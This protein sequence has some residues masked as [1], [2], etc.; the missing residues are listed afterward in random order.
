MAGTKL[1]YYI[2]YDFA[3]VYNKAL[4]W[5]L[6]ICIRLIPRLGPGN[7]E[8]S[9]GMRKVSAYTSTVDLD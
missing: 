3:R 9:L 1:Y 2:V 8:P 4:N 7:E 6:Y 5:S